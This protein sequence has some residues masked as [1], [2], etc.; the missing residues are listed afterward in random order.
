VVVV[1][2]VVVVVEVEEVCCMAAESLSRALSTSLAAWEAR[3]RK[4]WGENPAADIIVSTPSAAAAF[5]ECG[6]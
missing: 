3:V 1:V 5:A 2:V 6:R 4:S